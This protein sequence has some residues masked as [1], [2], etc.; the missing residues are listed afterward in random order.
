MPA[1]PTFKPPPGSI[2]THSHVFG[3]VTLYPF[4]AERKYTPQDASAEQ[5]FTLRNELGFKRNVIVQAACHGTDNG[6]MV[7]ACRASG[8]QARGV[9]TLPADVTDTTLAAMHEAGVRGARFN[10]VSRLVDPVPKADLLSIA[11]RIAPL[12]WHT[13]IHFDGPDLVDLES[14]FNDL[15]TDLVVD[16]IGRP[17]VSKDV[18]GPDFERFRRFMDDNERVWCKISCPERLSLTGA[19]TPDSK[20]TSYSD[21][22]P[23]ARC[24]V[25]DFSDRVLWGTDWPH[26]YLADQTPDDSQ[27]VDFIPHIAPTVQHQHKLLIDNPMRLYWP[28]QQTT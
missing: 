1:Q 4:A 13:V 19:V 24:I 3:P 8:G 6:A 11:E 12:G 18:T 22:V 16:H 7:N 25:E 20:R 2:D 28:D 17:D 15:P 5:L 21:V 27:L 14:F 26:P 9:A 10:F 23:F